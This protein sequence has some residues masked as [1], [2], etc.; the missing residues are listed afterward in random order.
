MNRLAQPVEGF[1][2][3]RTFLS[4]HRMQTQALLAIADDNDACN[5]TFQGG[6]SIL[7]CHGGIRMSYDLDFLAS[8]D[9]ITTEAVHR[10]VENT[11]Q[12]IEDLYGSKTTYG[13][14]KVFTTDS[15][16][17]LTRV[18]LKS[19]AVDDRPDIPLTNVKLEFLHIDP[20]DR[21]SRRLKALFDEPK[22]APLLGC[23]DADELVADKVVSLCSTRRLR[24]RDI[25]DVFFLMSTHSIGIESIRDMVSSK[26][27]TYGYTSDGLLE[28]CLQMRRLCDEDEG[29]VAGWSQAVSPL[30]TDVEWQRRLSDGEYARV[31]MDEALEVIERALRQDVPR[32]SFRR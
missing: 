30:L 14:I 7:M 16:N 26:I 5:V 22:A 27:E 24:A 1:G 10:V 17:L 31:V 15:S 18:Y 4:S 32:H 29:W 12:R 20:L 25:W 9:G 6:S 11:R 28:S 23:E 3:D 21:V 19:V 8:S 2:S 13:G